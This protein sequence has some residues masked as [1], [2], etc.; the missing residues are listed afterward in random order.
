M[1]I[2]YVR[3]G[4]VG[5]VPQLHLFDNY[6]IVY[7]KRCLSPFGFLDPVIFSRVFP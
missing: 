3:L 1:K 7:F 2:L 4:H 5:K 6:D